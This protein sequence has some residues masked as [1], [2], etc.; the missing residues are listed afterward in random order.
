MH[1]FSLCFY[2]YYWFTSVFSFYETF[3][4]Q[5]QAKFQKQLDLI[6]EFINVTWK[7]SS[8]KIHLYFGKLTKKWQMKKC[9]LK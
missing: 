1:H 4:F 9:H 5:G 3:G 2:Y 6:C 8:F 7:K